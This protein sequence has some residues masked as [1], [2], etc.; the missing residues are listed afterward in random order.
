MS[1]YREE[2]GDP[3][4]GIINGVI[5]SIPLWIGIIYAVSRIWNAL[6]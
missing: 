4:R 6:R 3:F 2:Y 1:N 5:I